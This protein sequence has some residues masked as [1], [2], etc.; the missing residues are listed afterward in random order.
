LRLTYQSG[1]F[2][3]LVPRG[4]GDVRVLMEEH[5]LDFSTPGSTEACAQ[6]FTREPY[7]A[8]AFWDYADASA[9]E[10]LAGMRARIEASWRPDGEGLH[11]KVP[12]DCEL[13]PFQK[14]GIAY[15]LSCPAAPNCL[16]GDAPGLGKT[17]QAIAIANEMGARRVLVLCPANLRLQWVAKIRQWTTMTWPYHV[18]PILNGRSG[19]NPTANWTVVSYDLART[20]NV[21]KALTKGTYD[22]L[23]L[24]EGHYL[25]SVDALRTRT[26]FGGGE[27]PVA[28]SLASR[29]AAT[30]VLTGTPL[31]NRPREAYTL[32]RGLCFDAI[33]WASEEEFKNRFNPSQLI[34]WTDAYGHE[35]RRID[36]RSG[37]HGELQ[38]R[39][40]SNFM[41][42][43]EKHG[44]NGVGYQLRIAHV[45]VLDLVH[46]EETTAVKQALM[47]EKLLDIDPEN[48]EGADMSA[49][50]SIATVRRLMGVAMAPLAAE[51]IDGCLDGGEEKI[52]VFA[53]HTEALDIIQAKLQKHGVMRIDGSVGPARRQQIVDR[54]VADPKVK[55]LLG[56]MIAMGTGTDGLQAVAWHCVLAEPDWVLGVNQQAIDRLDRGGQ[57]AQVQADLLVVPGS[58]SEKVLASALRKGATV[59]KVLDRRL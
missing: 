42:R 6:L 1:V 47:A 59:D 19:V 5:G 18:Y 52:I 39:L 10:P 20:P 13:A 58:F 31:P 24:D 4:E 15:A 37:R 14:A 16:V 40:R 49:L 23:I 17:M 48:L 53:H 54:Y 26:V 57:T 7:A 25:K 11:I 29:A 51:Y 56:N 32:A 55:V 50:G 8:V 28:A 38:A 30:V 27:A 9:R 22:L 2:V 44:P 43:R 33:D 21:W 35:K 12:E 46:L 45:P 41:V 3:L 36:E 34:T